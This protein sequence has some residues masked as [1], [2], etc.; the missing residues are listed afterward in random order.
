M[1]KSPKSL[2]DR[3]DLRPLQPSDYDHGFFECLSYLTQAPKPERAAFEARLAEVHKIGSSDIMVVINKKTKEVA[4]TAA[5]FYEPKFVRSLGTAAH[6]EDVVITKELQ[7]TGL[8][9][10]IVLHLVELA[11]KRKCYKVILDCD[12]KNIKFY[13]KCGFILKGAQMACYLMDHK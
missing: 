8:G 10:A 9:R 4:G 13:E 3:Y 2:D 12:T 11:R 1:S 7:G 5:V 6:I